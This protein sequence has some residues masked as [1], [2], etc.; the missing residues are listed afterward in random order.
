MLNCG[1]KAEKFKNSTMFYIYNN[2][3]EPCFAVSKF[4]RK[5]E[6]LCDVSFFAD[7]VFQ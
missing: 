7:T 4:P 2:L 3:C 5:R 1:K 6:D